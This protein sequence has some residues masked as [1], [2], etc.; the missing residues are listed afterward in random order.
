MLLWSSFE[1]LQHIQSMTTNDGSVPFPVRMFSIIQN[2][3]EMY[4]LISA[5]YRNGHRRLQ[6]GRN[7]VTLVSHGV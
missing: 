1:E 3:T 7:E 4:Q 6:E 5:Q 2:P